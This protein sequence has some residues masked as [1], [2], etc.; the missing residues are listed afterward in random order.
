MSLKISLTN[1]GIIVSHNTVGKDFSALICLVAWKEQHRSIKR[2]LLRGQE[3][4]ARRG[5]EDISS[6]LMNLHI[7]F[8]EEQLHHKRW[9]CWCCGTELTQLKHITLDPFSLPSRQG[10]LPCLTRALETGLL[11][12]P[13]SSSGQAKVEFLKLWA[14]HGWREFLPPHSCMWFS[15]AH[16]QPDAGSTYHSLIRLQ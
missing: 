8:Y 15:P 16:G 14:L 13:G 1:S 3:C 5:T 9:N 2:H 4:S 12:L 6:G 11:H 7:I 10:F